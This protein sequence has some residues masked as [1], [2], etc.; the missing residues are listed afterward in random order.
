MHNSSSQLHSTSIAL[1]LVIGGIAAHGQP[2]AEPAV[3]P[4]KAI[5]DN[6][7]FIE[8][9]YNQEP[10]VVQ[11]ILTANFSTDRQSGS[12]DRSWTLALTQEWPL[13]SQDHQLSYTIPY[14]FLE[15]GGSHQHGFEDIFL[16]YRY[17]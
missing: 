5:Q 12:Y 8:E 15:A 17:Q 14:S 11:H 2:V 7:F 3:P 6:S 9:A 10:G 4:A 13:F 1:A 16:N